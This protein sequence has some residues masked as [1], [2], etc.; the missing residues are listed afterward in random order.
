MNPA[1]LPAFRRMCA[2]YRWLSLFMI[3]TA[4]G[5]VAAAH[6]V[7]PSVGFILGRGPAADWRVYLSFLIWATP[8]LCYF[9]A[10]WLIGQGMGRLSRGALLQPTLARALRLAGLSLGFGGVLSVFCVMP[11]LRLIDPARGGYLHFDVPGM[12]LGMVGGALF[13]LGRVMDQAGRVQAELDEII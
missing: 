7:F 1:D 10:I 6:L 11:L 12:T 8:F 2:Q 9:L 5:V 3:A 13:L 4:G